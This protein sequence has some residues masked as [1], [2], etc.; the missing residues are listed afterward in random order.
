MDL[1][2]GLEIDNQVYE[3]AEGTL[4]ESQRE[5]SRPKPEMP[6]LTGCCFDSGPV[7]PDC[8]ESHYLA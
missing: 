7:G 2:S 4:P 6:G 5:E 3:S 8:P 1:I